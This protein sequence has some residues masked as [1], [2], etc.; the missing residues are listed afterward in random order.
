M[1]VYTFVM[2]IILQSGKQFL[3]VTKMVKYFKGV[4][5]VEFLVLDILMNKIH[6]HKY[7]TSVD[8]WK[9]LKIDDRAYA[10]LC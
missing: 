8:K 10:D 4:F 1:S 3:N 7:F 2:L 6:K 5:N 9:V